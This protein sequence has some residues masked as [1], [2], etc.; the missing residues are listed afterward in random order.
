MDWIT[1]LRSLQSDFIKRLSSGCLL[2][3]EIEGQYSELTVISG[4][5]LKT[6]RDFC[7]LMAEKYKRVSP[8]RDVFISYL[9]GKLGRKLLKN[10]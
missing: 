5:R 7:W 10:V 1:L 8:V 2:H 3:C 4:E 9:K 6:L